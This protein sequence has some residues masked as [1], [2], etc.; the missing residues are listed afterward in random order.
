MSK[1]NPRDAFVVFTPPTQNYLEDGNVGQVVISTA[2][3]VKQ[4]LG[5][6]SHRRLAQSRRIRSDEVEVAE[7]EVHRVLLQLVTLDGLSFLGV[8]HALGAI[9]GF[10]EPIHDGRT[11][12]KILMELR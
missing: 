3:R 6:E 7:L 1:I 11:R 9:E 5:G 10:A 2:D 8:F 4:F 12:G